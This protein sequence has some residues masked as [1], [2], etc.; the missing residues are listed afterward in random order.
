MKLFLPFLSVTS[1]KQFSYHDVLTSV[2]EDTVLRWPRSIPKNFD[3][4][5]NC[6][7]LEATGNIEKFKCK[8]EACYAICKGNSAPMPN[9]N[10]FSGSA[11]L[12]CK[13]PKAHKGLR[14]YLIKAHRVYYGAY[15]LWL[16][17]N[18]K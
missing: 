12:R 16:H 10:N 8:N 2:R 13:L 15:F 3:N 7:K 9:R 14:Y 4:W 17:V 18:R 1:A 11:K 5:E 6:P